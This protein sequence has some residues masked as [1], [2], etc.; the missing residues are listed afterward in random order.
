MSEE[1]GLAFENCYR[2]YRDK[3]MLQNLTSALGQTLN[4][5]VGTVEG[6]DGLI[7]DPADDSA[8]GIAVGTDPETFRVYVRLDCDR[9]RSM[10]IRPANIKVAGPK[11]TYATLALT[12]EVILQEITWLA[13]TCKECKRGTNYGER[14]DCTARQKLVFKWADRKRAPNP[15]ETPRCCDTTVSGTVNPFANGI[16][17]ELTKR[18]PVCAGTGFVDFSLFGAGLFADGASECPVCLLAMERDAPVTLL[19][20]GHQLHPN[21]VKDLEGHR[22][23]DPRQPKVVLGRGT[24]EACTLSCPLCRTLITGTAHD[25]LVH[26]SVPSALRMRRRFLEFV[27]LGMCVH[28]QLKFIEQSQVTTQVVQ[29]PQGPATSFIFNHVRAPH[30]ILLNNNDHA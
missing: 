15:N 26:H 6:M 2:L 11:S 27:R 20:C 4:G 22:A 24:A 10:R 25:N 3:V 8:K 14:L 9:T 13:D 1:Y 23:S 19:P 18:A 5:K 21:C 28:C 17:R 7:I 12:E 30:V 16:L 29:T